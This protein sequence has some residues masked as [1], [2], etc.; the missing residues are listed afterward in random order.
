MGITG[1]IYHDM[2][3]WRLKTNYTKSNLEMNTRILKQH[4]H[5]KPHSNVTEN[6]GYLIDKEGTP[7]RHYMITGMKL[8]VN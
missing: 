3:N 6:E 1:L 5:A 7:R 2:K 8:T 4:F